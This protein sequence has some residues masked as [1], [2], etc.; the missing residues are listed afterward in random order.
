MNRQQN[1]TLE[2]MDKQSLLHPVTSIADHNRNGPTIYASAAGV[3]MKDHS[4]RDLID[5]GAGLWCVNIGYG[6]GELA[7]AASN[8]M[9]E[10]SYQHLFGSASCEGAIRL[11]DRLLTLFREKANA[12]HMARVFFGT[13][14]SDAND[15]AFKLVRYYHNLLGRPEKKKIIS[16]MGGYHGVSHASGS[17]TGIPAYHKAFDQPV[18]GVLHMSCPHYYSFSL[19]GESEAEF[20]DRMIA[21]LKAMIEREG[22]HTIGAFIAEPV[23]GTGG[24]LLPSAGYFARVQEVL[25]EHDILFIVDEV[26]TGF[27]RIGHWF[28]TGAYDLKPDIVSL[29]KGITSAYFPLSASII[30]DRVMSVLEE[31]SATTGT[32]MHGFTYSGHPV[33]CAVAMANLD[34]IENE[35]MVENAAALGPYLLERLRERI[36]DCPYVG[37]VRGIGLMA[38]IEFVA[39][40]ASRRPFKEGTAPHR[41]VAKRAAEQGVLTR[42]LPF[43]PVNSFSPPLCITKAEIDEAVERYAGALEEVIPSLKA[44]AA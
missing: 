17:L 11:A 40:K 20:T 9:R 38:G 7:D 3:R 10:L 27:G 30:S 4:G 23:M 33:G 24:V 31:T 29:A 44:A 18:E 39:D 6:R 8:A 1:F 25:R 16:R 13:S 2:E 36:G 35:A 41:L 34:I 32:F 42:A 26:I 21:E 15:T 28:G 37:D 19:P 12:S 5:M 43:I 14:G 22:A